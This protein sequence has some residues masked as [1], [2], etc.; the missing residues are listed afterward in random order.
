MR[1]EDL[2]RDAR[3][4]ADQLEIARARGEAV[5]DLEDRAGRARS[6]AYTA[7][8]EDPPEDQRACEA[9][10]A[11][12]VPEDDE[13]DDFSRLSAEI[14][15]EYAERQAAVDIGGEIITRLGVLERLSVEPDP[16]TRMALFRS[17][18]P[19][20]Q[21]ITDRYGEL[22]QLSVERWRRGLSPVASNERALGIDDVESGLVK[23]LE[24]WRDAHGAIKI[25]PW[26]WWHVNGEAARALNARVDL[27]R[28]IEINNVYLASLGADPRSL[29]VG[30][31][32]RPRADRPPVPVAYTEFG[33]RP[34][35]GRRSKP[36]IMATYSAGGLGELT[37]L[38]HETGHA[39]HIAAIDTRPAFA[40]WPDSDAFTEALAELPAL[41]TA[42]PAWQQRWLGASSSESVSI[43]GRYADV[44]LDVCWSLFEIRCHK[45]P[46]T[47]PDQIW[48][49]L[50]STYLG[51]NPHPGFSWWAMRGQLIQAPG[52]MVN[53]GLAAIIAA[54]LRAAIRSERGDWIDGDPGWYE[55][56][57]QRL[58]KWGLERSSG[59]VIADVLGRPPSPDALV[60]EIRRGA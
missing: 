7:L 43:K 59:D 26:D 25:E 57:S 53:Y 40:D 13:E 2:Y 10:S 49:E 32:I 14:E 6:I 24:A 41:D 36:W 17:L 39:I 18:L 28:M 29:D 47:G 33:G 31:D 35:P 45:Q 37:E 27:D 60:A 42:E 15:K 50:T 56:V 21:S 54:D 22:R 46:A 44:V 34:G 38:V 48:T 1:A 8:I 11:W 20:W 58:Y 55:H 9:I 4:L 52:Y 19:V 5:D 3:N 16:G 23:I 51:I 30:F 12:F